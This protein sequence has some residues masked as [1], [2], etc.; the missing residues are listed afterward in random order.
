MTCPRNTSIMNALLERNTQTHRYKA[1]SIINLAKPSIW[2]YA[3][4][5]ASLVMA[6][7]PRRSNIHAMTLFEV[8]YG[9]KPDFKTMG[10]F[11]S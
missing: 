8:H 4:H 7:S 6:K 9:A 1:F 2:E 11:G 10:I 5:T 3:S